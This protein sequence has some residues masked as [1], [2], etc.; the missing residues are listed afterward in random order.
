MT[1]SRYGKR[2]TVKHKNTL[3]I[4]ALVDEIKPEDCPTKFH[5]EKWTEIIPCPPHT[6]WEQWAV[7]MDNG[8]EPGAPC[9][10]GS[11]DS[12]LAYAYRLNL[13]KGCLSGGVQEK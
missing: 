10:F 4:I 5:A 2:Q 7:I 8:D 13:C 12:M 3:R 1:P 6:P 11:K 9:A